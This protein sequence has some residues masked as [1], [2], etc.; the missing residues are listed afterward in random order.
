MKTGSISN[1]TILDT[2]HGHTQ[3][4]RGYH[5][6]LTAEE[7]YTLGAY[8]KGIPNTGNYTSANYPP[9]DAYPGAFRSPSA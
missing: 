2:Y 9:V 4:N 5:Y 8:Y 7:P 6:H 3:P 1:R